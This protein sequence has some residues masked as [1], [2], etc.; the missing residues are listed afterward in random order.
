MKGYTSLQILKA[1]ALALL[2]AASL[3][4]SAESE[5][6]DIIKYRQNVMKANGAHMASIAA[7]IQGKVDYRQDLTHHVKA[8]QEINKNIT[9]LFPKDSDF[10]D[11]KAL[12][13]VWQKSADF[14]KAA[15]DARV[16]AD[17]LA[18]AVAAGDSKAYPARL[19][20]LSDSCKGCHK[21]FRKEEK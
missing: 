6:E 5:P 19:K 8:V 2:L 20:A 1:G 9:A 21:D 12:D 13:A 11:T 16:N 18:K 17:A 4:V 15:K 14:E 7:I 10:G 3:P